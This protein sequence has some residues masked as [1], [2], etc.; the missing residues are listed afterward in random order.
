[1]NADQQTEQ[2]IQEYIHSQYND[3][4]LDEQRQIHQLYLFHQKHPEKF[5][6]LTK[7]LEKF[8]FKITPPT[9]EEYLDHRNGWITKPF[10]ATLFPHVREDFI[11]ILNQDSNYEQIVEYGATRCGKSHMARMII[12][13]IIIYLHCLRHP[14]LYYNLAPTT[15]LS[16]YLMS[17]TNEKLNQILLEPIYK[18]FKMCP[19]MR[20]ERF[21]EKV[22]EQQ[23]KFGNEDIFWSTASTFGH[24]TLASDVSLNTGTDF[25]S[26]M[27]SDLLFL[28]VSE[29]NFFIEQAG[30]THEEIFQLYSDGLERIQ[31]TVGDNYLGMVYLD[32]SAN[33]VDN[34]IEKYILNDLQHQKGVFYKDRARWDCEQHQKKYK[35]WLKNKD[36]PNKVSTFKVCT[37][38][39]STPPQ[40]INSEQELKTINSN[41]II[42]VPIDLYDAF[43]RNI[44]KSIKDI[45]GKPTTSENKFIQ[46]MNLV[47][48]MWDKNLFNIIDSV[49][50]D[51]SETPENLIWN[52]IKPDLFTMTI[53]NKWKLKR[54][55]SEPRFLHVDHAFSTKGDLLG[56]AMGHFERSIELQKTLNVLDFAFV[57]RSGHTGI[58]LQA[59]EQFI[60]DLKYIGNVFLKL[61]S[62]DSF[63]SATMKQN[64]N[65][66]D[67][68]TIILSVDRTVDA[69][70]NFLNLLYEETVRVGRNIFLKNN[71]GSL[72]TTKATKDT[73]VKGKE[74]IDH[75]KGKM[76]KI[77]NGDWTKSS[78]G[79]H[80][81]DCSD[82]C[83][84]VLFNMSNSDII[85]STIYEKENMKLSIKV[86][87]KKIIMG[88]AMEK[89][90]QFVM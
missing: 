28:S 21:K 4:S 66:N 3:L 90:H 89:L 45:A 87:D 72:M 20:K 85:S 55:N 46:D 34:S 69:Y 11:E 12:H 25:L 76:E 35:V 63:Q 14:Q 23:Y 48:N 42:D 29:I 54:A 57:I 52:K 50:A 86:E 58:N 41:L 77:Y 43:K 75:S 8:I 71:M 67:I 65:R 83:A 59:V 19:R 24:L 49:V 47:N 56:I 1:M 31:A 16:I 84:G 51:A 15:S 81:K 9:P 17:F 22:G 64:L 38:D 30:T 18:I 62:S 13:Y 80:G 36:N 82:P 27:G 74:K 44:T 2:K 32:S 6:T 78:A 79:K 73:K 37:G 7:K 33:D 40:I 60:L 26:F 68:D 39:G 5:S 10:E 88:D 53:D 61:V 70:I